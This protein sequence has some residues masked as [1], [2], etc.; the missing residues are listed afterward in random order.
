MMN[1]L[2]DYFGGI[3]MELIDIF[4]Q[5]Y[6]NIAKLNLFPHIRQRF[7]EPNKDILNAI[8]YDKIC[9]PLIDKDKRAKSDFYKQCFKNKD[10]VPIYTI[11]ERK[12]MSCMPCD[13]L[14]SLA[15]YLIDFAYN[16]FES[17]AKDFIEAS[18][19][20]NEII[21]D[22]RDLKFKNAKKSGIYYIKLHTM[23]VQMGM[24]VLI[25]VARVSLK[26]LWANMVCRL[27]Y[28]LSLNQF[29]KAS[30]VTKKI[31]EAMAMINGLDLSLEYYESVAD[32]NQ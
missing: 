27:E 15:N 32:M 10:G 23:N 13:E 20:S 30:D 24:A 4:D 5:E 29:E 18:P 1:V 19:N 9:S 3:T 12:K 21:I 8:V 28:Y 2:V 26:Y 6:D 16:K 17:Y 22:M 11:K 7:Y 25:R 14:K 31:S